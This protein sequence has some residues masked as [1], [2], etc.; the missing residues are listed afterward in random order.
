MKT[1]PTLNRPDGRPGGPETSWAARSSE[2]TSS[3]SRKK[4]AQIRGGDFLGARKKW[5]KK[6]VKKSKKSASRAAAEVAGRGS[7]EWP[8]RAGMGGGWGM[9]PWMWKVVVAEGSRAAGDEEDH[10]DDFC[11]RVPSACWRSRCEIQCPDPVPFNYL[12]VHVVE[13][14]NPAKRLRSERGCSESR[15]EVRVERGYATKGAEHDLGHE[16]VG[17]EVRKRRSKLI[18]QAENRWAT[19]IPVSVGIDFP[20]LRRRIRDYLDDWRIDAHA[21]LE[22][23]G[24]TA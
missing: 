23:V 8:G 17:G 14:S 3:R 16:G 11:P 5:R 9:G 21:P 6:S 24:R 12:G 20:S 1:L 4:C 7:G 15:P 2:L 10:V 13:L 22:Q 18:G 19:A